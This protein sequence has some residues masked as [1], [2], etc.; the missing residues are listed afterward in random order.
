MKRLW[1]LV[2]GNGSGKSTFYETVLS[3]YGLP[4][5]NADLIAKDVFPEDPEGKSYEAAR[6]A[7]A[8]R[9]SHIQQGTSFCFETVF[10]HFSKIDFLSRAKA[11]G[12]EIILIVIHVET[13][14]LN[15]ARISQ[16]VEEGG[17]NVPHDKVKARI[18]RTLEN[19]KTAIPLC[20][21]VRVLDNSSLTTPFQEVLTIKNGVRTLHVS[22]VPQWASDFLH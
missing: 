8:M 10:S 20:D 3:E 5:V 1:V 16:R 12:Y 18:P 14:D 15:L 6:L 13:T 22:P 19:V 11:K 7:E 17:H 21:E 9:E 2:G 4:F